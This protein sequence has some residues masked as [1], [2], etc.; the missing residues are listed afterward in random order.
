MKSSM[1]LLQ[2]RLGF[3]LFGFLNPSFFSMLNT[4]L[5]GWPARLAVTALALARPVQHQGRPGH[6]A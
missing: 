6:V 2:L 5:R 4:F 3:L 1:S